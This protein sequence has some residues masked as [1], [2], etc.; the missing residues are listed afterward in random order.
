[1]IASALS[2]RVTDAKPFE[3]GRLLLAWIGLVPENDAT[4]GKV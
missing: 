4:G 2:A 3:N 1:V